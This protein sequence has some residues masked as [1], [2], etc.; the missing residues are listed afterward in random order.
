MS[1]KLKRFL[2]VFSVLL[3][4]SSS[5]LYAE[6]TYVIKEAEMKKLETILKNY[7]EIQKNLEEQK[8]SYEKTIQNLE[9][10]LTKLQNENKANCLKTGI[11]VGCITISVGF[12]AGIIASSI[13]YYNK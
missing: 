8:K 7:E 2:S 12:A 4:L 3:L 11:I 9:T 1:Q 6:N 5:L 13:V 10:G